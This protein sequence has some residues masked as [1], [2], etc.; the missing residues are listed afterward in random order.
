MVSS[1]E[2]KEEEEGDGEEDEEGDL[3][4]SEDSVVERALQE[5]E[6]P[7]VHKRIVEVERV[8]RV[9]SMQAV[10]HVL[11]QEVVKWEIKRQARMKRVFGI[12]EVVEDGLDFFSET[13]GS[14]EKVEEKTEKEEEEGET[15]EA[16]GEEGREVPLRKSKRHYAYETEKDKITTEAFKE[17][18]KEE[19]SEKKYLQRDARLTEN[20]REIAVSR[21]AGF[22]KDRAKM[23]L[24]IMADAGNENA[25]EA[26]RAVDAAEGVRDR[27]KIVQRERRADGKT[28]VGV[29]DIDLSHLERAL[30]RDITRVDW[31]SKLDLL[32][33]EVS[34]Q[35]GHKPPPRNSALAPPQGMTVP[36]CK[37]TGYFFAGN[38]K[39]VIRKPEMHIIAEGW[40]LTAEAAR[41]E[42]SRMAV[43]ECGK[44]YARW[45]ESSEEDGAV[46][47][48]VIGRQIFPA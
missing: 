27:Q 42:A 48:T 20:L 1:L 28:E 14:S 45:G 33:R 47:S 36:Y 30:R 9:R 37:V 21:K 13:E 29:D 44:A 41:Q 34:F 31:T 7:T 8:E 10:L 12:K 16:E 17:Q 3:D 38:R 18:A 23:A 35:N 25:I 5:L 24:Q 46:P 39:G 19:V 11:R 26:L 2:D 43:R 22:Y 40:G 4:F 32:M 6:G 15:T